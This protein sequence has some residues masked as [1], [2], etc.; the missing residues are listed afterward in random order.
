MSLLDAGIAAHFRTLF[1]LE[2]IA[3]VITRPSPS[4]SCAAT[5]VLGR[6]EQ[7]AGET[8][9]FTVEADAQDLIVKASDY[10][11]GTVSEPHLNDQITATIG[12]VETTWRVVVRSGQ[13]VFRRMDP[14]GTYLRVFCKRK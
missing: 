7:L 1:R 3:A 8:D 5:I 11:P 13:Q 12:D 10:K 14:K 6:T 4:G 2:G 9:A